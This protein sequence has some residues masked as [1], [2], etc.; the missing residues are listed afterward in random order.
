MHKLQRNIRNVCCNTGRTLICSSMRP[1][2]T[3]YGFIVPRLLGLIA[4]VVM[5][6]ACQ[7]KQYHPQALNPKNS[8]E[9][10]N[11][12]NVTDADFIRFLQA[13][14]YPTQYLPPQQW[15]IREIADA[16]LF[17][18]PDLQVARA[19]WRMAKAAEITAGMRPNPALG[20]EVQHHSN[21]TDTTSAWSYGLGIDIPVI[22]ANKLEIRLDAARSMS[23][24]MRI[25]IAQSAWQTRQRAALA[26]VNWQ[27]SQAKNTLYQQE[28]TAR[29]AIVDML[30]AR[31]QHGMISNL[32][33]SNAKLFLQKSQQLAMVEQ[34]QQQALHIALAG[35]V[36][37]TPEM[38]NAMPLQ[39]TSW[40]T[41]DNVNHQPQD[42]ISS[43]QLNNWRQDALLNRLDIRVGLAKYAVAEQK[44]R[45]E[46]ARQYPDITLSPA[47]L[48][49]QGNQVWS[50]GIKSLLMLL[51]RNQGPIAE[52]QALRDK[53]A[54][55]FLALQANVISETAQA[56]AQYTALLAQLK[57]AANMVA[58]QQT[59]LQR[60]QIQFKRGQADHVE[61]TSAQLE[62]L[63]AKQVLTDVYFRWL[64]A[65]LE[66]ENTLQKPI[67]S[68]A[69]LHIFESALMEGNHP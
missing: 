52:A 37:I 15:G 46:I 55:Q 29:Q 44:L 47:Y 11:Q 31:Y 53:E 3:H 62:T 6:N 51:N 67:I 45:L 50:L 59:Q 57:Q 10:F 23:E 61:L 18:H 63:S 38:L 65:A 42:S 30:Q 60:V 32:D 1:S 40:Q 4:F 64:K 9:Q 27:E 5:L 12:R 69:P 43:L 58:E 66:V 19:E 33:L 13:L 22:T 20:V 34:T 25:Q 49:D 56:Q 24:A 41:L 14:N 54:A 28:I 21:Q 16:A 7:F 2:L 35:A 17:F 48:F 39:T 26:F 8:L 68:Q 36:G